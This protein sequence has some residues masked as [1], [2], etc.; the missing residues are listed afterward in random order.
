MLGENL[1]G[2]AGQVLPDGP[3][4]QGARSKAFNAEVGRGNVK[5]PVCANGGADRLFNIGL[6]AFRLFAVDC[7]LLNQIDY[8]DNI[9]TV[10][11]KPITR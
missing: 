4:V 2:G 10:R 7:G 3:D 1:V 11:I 9:L 5:L 6:R 8:T